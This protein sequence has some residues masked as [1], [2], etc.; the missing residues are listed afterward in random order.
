MSIKLP[1]LKKIGANTHRKKILLL[2]DDIKFHSGVATI[3]REIVVGLAHKF[4]FVQLAAALQ[5]PEH[6]KRIDLSDAINAERNIDDASVV[7]YCHSGYGNQI[8]LREV[9]DLEK[10]DMVLLITDPRFFGFVF[11]MEHELRSHYKIPIAYLNIWDQ[12]SPFPMWNAPFYASCDLLMS[13][14]RGTKVVNKEVLSY[15]G[16]QTYDLDLG[17]SPNGTAL[18]YVPHGS[19]AKYFYKITPESPDWREYKEFE[20]KVKTQHGVDFVVLFNNRNIRR[21]Q[22]GDVIL[23]YKLF[24]DKLP[25]DTAQR[26]ALFMKTQVTDENGTDLLAVKAAICPKYKV[27]FSEDIMPTNAMNWLY[28]A[29][30]AVFYMSSAEGFGLAANEGL[31]TGKVLI[32]PVTGGLQDQMR[33]EDENGDWIK[34]DSEFTSNHRKK[35]KKC[36]D[37]AIP[38]FPRARQLQGSVPTPYI[39]DDVCDAED[40]ANALYEVY[41]MGK[42]ERERRGNLGSNWVLGSESGMNHV[43]MCKRMEF[44]IDH[45][46]TNFK[47]RQ[48]FEILK[49][50]PKPPISNNGITY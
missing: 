13:I 10:P 20:A 4:D 18:A 36:G 3:S 14:N 29:S 47:P 48:R 45:V 21:K 37:W 11:Q 25:P 8:V 27:I 6:G 17:E 28:N 50:N 26:C 42:E 35:Y 43:D 40:A 41:N 5:H 15:N 38:I 34:F 12:A 24:C 19:S 23:A 7:Q 16:Y 44:A 1:K 22:P 49:S 33:F 46:F 30:D 9:I 2:S 32:A 31:M 39:F